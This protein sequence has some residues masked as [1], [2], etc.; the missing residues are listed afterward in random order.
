MLMDFADVAE[1]WQPVWKCLGCGREMI[2]DEERFAEDE[3]ILTH[4][5]GEVSARA[6]RRS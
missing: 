4:V 1:A 5:R 2:A 6:A 3:R